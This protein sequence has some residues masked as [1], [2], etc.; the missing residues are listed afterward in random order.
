[1]SVDKNCNATI[2][3]TVGSGI[4]QNVSVH[5]TSQMN[6]PHQNPHHHL[7][8]QQPHQQQAHLHHI[9]QSTINN[10]VIKS[11][12]QQNHQQGS[13]TI[14]YNKVRLFELFID[15]ITYIPIYIKYK[16]KITKKEAKLNL[17]TS[18]ICMQGMDLRA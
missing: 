10:T 1:M 12:H 3:Q 11:V 2:N 5:P 17:R 7:H 8:Q 13:P 9:Q 18:F 6:T 14:G 4:N 15:C 16:K